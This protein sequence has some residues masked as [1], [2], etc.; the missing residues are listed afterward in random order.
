MFELRFVER[1][2]TKWKATRIGTVEQSHGS[3]LILQSRTYKQPQDLT[4][5]PQTFGWTGDQ[6]AK[7]FL[8]GWSDWRDV[9][10]VREEPANANGPQ[11]E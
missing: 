5:S 6:W 4:G 8:S 2:T 1:P 9:P 7:H 11:R 10:V 3:Q